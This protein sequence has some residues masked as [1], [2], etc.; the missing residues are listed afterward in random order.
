MKVKKYLQLFKVPKWEYSKKLNLEYSKDT[1][2]V[3]WS[4]QIEA[5]PISCLN[6]KDNKIWFGFSHPPVAF[7]DKEL[8]KKRLVKMLTGDET[9]FCSYYYQGSVY[10]IYEGLMLRIV[11]D[12]EKYSLVD[13]FRDHSLLQYVEVVFAYLVNLSFDTLEECLEGL[14]K[15]NI[16][17]IHLN[18]VTLS[19]DP[20]YYGSVN[21]VT[22][23]IEEA[24]EVIKEKAPELNF[25]K[26]RVVYDFEDVKQLTNER[27]SEVYRAKRNWFDLL[28]DMAEET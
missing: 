3:S 7:T 4:K 15:F 24:V 23:A 28:V 5:L 17:P 8:T 12:T 19:Y 18:N 20:P 1:R 26:Q 13:V 22:K 2:R 6:V 14:H 27:D 21:K 25:V 11:Y 10:V 16:L 9:T